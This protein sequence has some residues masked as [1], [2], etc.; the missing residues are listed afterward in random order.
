MSMSRDF[1]RRES[2]F[3]VPGLDSVLDG[4][5]RNP[6][7]MDRRDMTFSF[8]VFVDDGN[9]DA[10]YDLLAAA[11][12]PGYPVRLVY[13]TDALAQ[14]FTIGSNPSIK[15]TLTSANSWGH[16]GF[17]DFA[18]TFRIRPDWRKRSPE[19]TDVTYSAANSEV[20]AADD[21]ERYTAPGATTITSADQPFMMDATGTAGFD[22]PTLPDTAPTFALV[23][24]CGGD[25]G[26]EVGNGTAQTTDTSGNR[27]DIVFVLPFNLPTASDSCSVVLASQSFTYTVGGVVRTFRPTKPLYQREYFRV[28][29]GVVNQCYV[30]AL[31]SNPKTGGYISRN[32]FKK[33]A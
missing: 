22:L 20:Y 4:Y 25:D 21:S 30:R 13:T 11:I 17:C 8:R 10:A 6:G 1:T 19:I 31:G 26:I 16:G 32:F 5:G 27:H 33:R 29:P 15:H 14:W 23:G 28:Q 3:S 12:A 9:L 24:P 2:V 7:P 18:V